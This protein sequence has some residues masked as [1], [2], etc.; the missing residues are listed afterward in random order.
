MSRNLAIAKI[1]FKTS[2]QGGKTAF[3][4]QSAEERL[5]E[6]ES[7]GWIAA[8]EIFKATTFIAGLYKD[9]IDVAVLAADVKFIDAQKSLSK[10]DASS[11][12]IQKTLKK[13]KKLPIKIV[14]DVSKSGEKSI[15]SFQ[16]VA[17]TIENTIDPIAKK[18]A[19]FK[20]LQQGTFYQV[21]TG[22][23]AAGTA[24]TIVETLRSE[25]VTA[26]IRDALAGTVIEEEL[27]A[28]ANNYA[29]TITPS[30]S[31][32]SAGVSSA[33]ESTTSAAETAPDNTLAIE[34]PDGFGEEFLAA[35]AVFDARFAERTDE[36]FVIEEAV[37]GF[38]EKAQ[39]LR[40]DGDFQAFADDLAAKFQAITAV[41]D[42]LDVLSQL[43]RTCRCSR[44]L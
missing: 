41:L 6:A 21:A 43:R 20:K 16:D 14:K 17:E 40:P 26:F 15:K 33:S 7:N 8:L 31:P 18:L 42:E 34:L 27:N 3:L 24:V 30:V 10:I 39:L 2:K 35:Q 23:D 22:L 11:T 29:Q 28:V 19:F 13:G 37:A 44:R 12:G 9:F 4:A 32:A 38:I 25:A 36:F 1:G 5:A